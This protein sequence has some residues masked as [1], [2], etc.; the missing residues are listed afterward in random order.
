M[1]LAACSQWLF[2]QSFVPHGVD[3]LATVAG[4][5]RSVNI[6]DVDGDG[7]EDIFF[8]RG[9]KGGQD[10]LLFLNREGRFILAPASAITQD[11]SPAD[12]ATFA[13]VDNDGDPD[14]FVVTWYGVS[15]FFYR[16]DSDGRF[17]VLEHSGF[18]DLKTFSE[19]A[20]WGDYDRDGL[21][22]LYIANS[23]G[24]Q[25]NLLFRN[26]GAGRWERILVGA[27]VEDARPSRGVSW[28][29]F[30]QDGDVDL[31]VCNENGQPNDLYRNDGLAGFTA[32]S[33]GDLGTG[34]RGS[35]SASWGD[36]DNDG[37]L[38]V[39]IANAGYFQE[40]P[41][42][43][44]RNNGDGTFA[45]V[46]TGDLVADGGC[47]YGSAFADYDNDGDLDLAV[48]NG[49]CRGEIR[50][51]LYRNDG[52]GTFSRDT[53]SIAKLITPCS[54]GIAWGDLNKDGAPDLVVANCR[55]SESLPEPA[56]AVFMNQGNS[57]HWIKVKLKGTA[58]NWS[59]I[60]ARIRVKAAGSS[61]WQLR[62]VSAQSGYCGQNSLIQH[63]G[64]GAAAAVDSLVVE[65]PGGT[66]QVRN[67]VKADQEI[68]I[69]EQ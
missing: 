10:N 42:Q 44:F 66:R 46:R 65:W 6:V 63:F 15:N 11:R 4:D 18:T 2:S 62:E 40:Q 24:D 68:E 1:A 67:G 5:S 36:I 32:V 7:W 60:G 31:F 12:G 53:F 30:D 56:N 69:I 41:N 58:S 25:R 39:F 38:D 45:E 21:L 59:A 8:S 33:A 64:L 54:F 34:E 61:T 43:L 37:D 48:A 9:P 55:N 49:Y 19:T 52:H 26:A 16:N 23:E 17:T 29:D 47:S 22:D 3:L 57:A 35:M 13:D 28:V 51:F 27:P 14:A 20:V 50:N